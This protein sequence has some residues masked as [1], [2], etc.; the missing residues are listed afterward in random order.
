MSTEES[1]TVPPR[2]LAVDDEE[3]VCESIRRVLVAEG[4]DVRTTTSSREGLELIRREAFDLLF[5]D[6]K[7]P[8][9][10]GIELLRAAR[11]VSPD[12]DPAGA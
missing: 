10:D 5:L 12:T 7:M 11:S 1:L 9:L 8:E 4:Y 2:V 3:V 6:I